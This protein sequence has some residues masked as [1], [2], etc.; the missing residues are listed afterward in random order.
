M[1]RDRVR[2]AT[3]NTDQVLR[4]AL[5]L[6]PQECQHLFIRGLGEDLVILAHGGEVRVHAEHA[7]FVGYPGIFV[8]AAACMLV[9]RYFMGRVTKGEPGEKPAA[10]A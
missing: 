5:R 6:C 3:R 8:F 2:Y 1:V 7:D 10:G 4:S 9:A